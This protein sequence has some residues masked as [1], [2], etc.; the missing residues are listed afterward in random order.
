MPTEFKA[1]NQC[2][3]SNA[4]LCW[5]VAPAPCGTLCAYGCPP[6]ST[7]TKSAD[8]WERRGRNLA[9]SAVFDAPPWRRTRIF[10]LEKAAR[11]AHAASL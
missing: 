3:A 9:A 7:R 11:R 10:S 4:C 5:E 1:A 6:G 8:I 2:G